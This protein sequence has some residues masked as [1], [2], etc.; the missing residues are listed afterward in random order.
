VNKKANVKIFMFD[1]SQDKEPRYNTYEVEWEGLTVL[2][3]LK[4]IYE[5]QDA[6]I[7]FRCGCDGVG[8]ARCAGCVVEV[9]GL[10]ALACQVLATQE[11]VIKPHRKFAIIKDL[12]VDFEKERDGDA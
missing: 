1:P 2:Q 8:P 6:N 4:R 12:V 5:D 3:V 10:P 11:M 7:A 9:N